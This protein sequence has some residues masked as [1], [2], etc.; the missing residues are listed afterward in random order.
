MAHIFSHSQKKRLLPFFIIIFVTCSLINAQDPIDE[1]DGI[2]LIIYPARRP[3]QLVN[4]TNYVQMHSLGVYGVV[5]PNVFDHSVYLER[6]ENNNLKVIPQHLWNDTEDKPMWRYTDA[7]YS[8]WEAEGTTYIDTSNGKAT[9][10]RSS[11]SAINTSGDTVSVK[12]SANVPAGETII[13]GPG[14]PQNVTY[15]FGDEGHDTVHYTAAY[16]M[17]IK[18]GVPQIPQDYLDDVVCTLLVTNLDMWD[19]S[20]EDTTVKLIMK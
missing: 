14:Y 15:A 19:I 8:L 16:R 2:P 5:A 10:Y 7:H 9:L 17:K 12:A 1:Y 11:Y 6:F 13:Y 3:S 4:P 20:E 18:P